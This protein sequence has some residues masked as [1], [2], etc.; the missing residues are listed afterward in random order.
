MKVVLIL[1]F[2]S[3]PVFAEE[4]PN[5]CND[6]EANK[7][8]VSIA[9]RARAANDTDVIELYELRVELCSQVGA[10]WMSVEDATAIF[11]KERS[12]VVGIMQDKKH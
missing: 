1:L 10:G 2:F 5:Y 12:R 4:T 9:Q 7:H 11:E 6:T 3:F 8:W